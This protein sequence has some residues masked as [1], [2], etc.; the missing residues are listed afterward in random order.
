MSLGMKIIVPYKHP[1]H[2]YST[3][4][5]VCVCVCVCGWVG[6]RERECVCEPSI[7]LKTPNSI[8]D[9]SRTIYEKLTCYMW[10]S[11]VGFW[12]SPE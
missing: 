3:K 4:V 10:T 8:L 6:G 2:I 1:I 5:C 11:L 9:G 12:T 7:E